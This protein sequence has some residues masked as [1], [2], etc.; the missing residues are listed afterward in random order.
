MDYPKLRGVNAFPTQI[1]GQHMI[2]IQDP[3]G[4]SQRAVFLPPSL[5]FIVSLFDGKHSILD[6]Q[7]EY[8]RKYGEL[9]YREKIEQIVEQLDA[10]L[11][12]DSEGFRD[13]LES[14]KRDFRLAH[15]REAAFAGMS[16][17]SDPIIL[18]GKIEEYFS[19]PDGPGKPRRE[20]PSGALKGIIAPH[21]D[22]QR[23]GPCYAFAHK[24]VREESNADLFIILGTAH[25]EMK[26]YFSLTL[27]DF[28]TPLGTA[29]TNKAFVEALSKECNW[30][31]FEDE[32][33]HKREHSIEFQVIFLQFLYPGKLLEIVPI[34]C[35][36]FHEAIER[37]IPPREI[38]PIGEF[39]E[40]L[41]KTVRS[42]DRE[43]CLIASADLAHIGLH[44]GD[45]D[46][47]SHMVSETRA[48]DLEMLAYAEKV[49]A[50][51]FYH[52]I[53][54]EGDRRRI[55]GFPSIYVLLNINGINQG[56]LLKYAQSENPETQSAVT[57]AS[58][59]FY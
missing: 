6:I 12:L 24:E 20:N 53:R 37:S 52:A 41:Q 58:L 39:I 18:R 2:C 32:F 34:L 57:F 17:D 23:G 7:A 13:I 14:E 4:F 28:R 43:V 56:K 11:L 42:I 21:I 30:D 1:Q 29:E 22:F 36:S 55:C 45:G 16:Y 33:A 35:G 5:F 3:Q 9:I 15:V 46:P 54:K 50:E 10:Q 59:A 31:P 48:R 47:A 44:F 38:P 40:V 25:C 8:M 51:G 49:D 19:P 26:N 27:K